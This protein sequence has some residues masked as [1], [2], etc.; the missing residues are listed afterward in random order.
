MVV[1]CI[2]ATFPGWQEEIDDD[3]SIVDVK[4]FPHRGLL[5]V[6]AL[7]SV[8]ASIL[9]LLSMLWQHT[10]SVTF[11]TNVENMNYRLVK[12][13]VGAVGLALGWLAVGAMLLGSAGLVVIISAIR[14]LDKSTSE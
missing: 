12:G 9:A 5:A 6:A 2:L 4:P 13:H 11:V 1:I 14:V 3:G 7:L 8:L 10:A